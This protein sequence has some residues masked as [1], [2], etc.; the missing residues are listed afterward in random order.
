MSKAGNYLNPSQ[1]G[2]HVQLCITPLEVPNNV[3][4][5]KTP[6]KIHLS[7]V[8]GVLTHTNSLIAVKE[9]FFLSKTFYPHRKYFFK[10]SMVRLDFFPLSFCTFVHESTGCP[11]IFLSSLI[12]Y[13]CTS[14]YRVSRKAAILRALFHPFI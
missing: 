5:C 13:N 9:V 2:K 3:F 4:L 10:T 14:K 12:L 1:G 8:A 7:G 6:N 11:M